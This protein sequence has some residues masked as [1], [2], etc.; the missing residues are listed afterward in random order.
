MT[1]HYDFKHDIFLSFNWGNED[2][3]V[4]TEGRGVEETQDP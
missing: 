4:G 2:R 3:E 1:A